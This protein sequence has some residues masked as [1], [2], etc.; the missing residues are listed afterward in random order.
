[1]NLNEAIQNQL[2]FVKR[3]EDVPCFLEQE[4]ATLLFHVEL[5]VLRYR[6]LLA[7][8]KQGIFPDAAGSFYQPTESYRK[9]HLQE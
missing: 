4:I 5:K 1:M 2:V 6:N 8:W 3:A 9:A 7:C